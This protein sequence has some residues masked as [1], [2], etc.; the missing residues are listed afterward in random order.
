MPPRYFTSATIAGAHD[1]Q[2][3]LLNA[4]LSN[5]VTSETIATVAVVDVCE[6]HTG[7]ICNLA[8]QKIHWVTAMD[9]VDKSSLSTQCLYLNLEANFLGCI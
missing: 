3:V 7:H 4:I 1:E 6:R 5:S 9:V 2:S 8:Q